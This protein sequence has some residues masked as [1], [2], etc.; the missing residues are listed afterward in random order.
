[1]TQLYPIPAAPAESTGPTSLSGPGTADL[2]A[3]ADLIGRPTLRAA[4]LTAPN[5][6][7]TVDGMSG[8]R[9]GAS[10]GGLPGASPVRDTPSEPPPNRS[11]SAHV[12]A[13]VRPTR[14]RAD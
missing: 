3:L 5:Q 6:P 11:V 10:L 9:P 12:N 7:S 4:N 13:T 8:V 2:A 1:M 14:D